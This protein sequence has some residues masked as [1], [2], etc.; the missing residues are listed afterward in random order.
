[1]SRAVADL[2]ITP[3]AVLIDGLHCPELPMPSLAIPHGD[4]NIPCISAA[5]IIAKVS[6]DR[7]MLKYDAIY[8]GYGFASHKGYNTQQHRQALLKLGLT[9]LHRR[10]FSTITEILH[11][12]IDK[13]ISL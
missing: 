13:Q 12:S 1:M 6:R 8:P 10:N 7:E 3:A 4:E 9:P 5:A 2:S 11:S